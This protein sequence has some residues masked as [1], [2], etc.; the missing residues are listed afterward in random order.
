MS[1]KLVEI[2]FLQF[3]QIVERLAPQFCFV[4]DKCDFT[5]H[6]RE[7]HAILIDVI[8]TLNLDCNRTKELITTIDATGICYDDLCGERWLSYLKE[9]AKDFLAEVEEL[10]NLKAPDCDE[11]DCECDV[12]KWHT[13]PTKCVTIIK[14]D[15]RPKV[16]PKVKVIVKKDC[17]CEKVCPP[18]T[19]EPKQVILIKCDPCPQN[20]DKV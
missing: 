17:R 1:D 8:F 2:I 15:C 19:H 4:F 9:L 6:V 13:F 12:A 7:N 16:C 18:I 10:K 14:K 11:C 3:L 20:G 5:F